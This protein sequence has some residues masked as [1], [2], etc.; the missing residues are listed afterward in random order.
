[1]AGPAA[2]QDS[3][4]CEALRAAQVVAGP[5]AQQVR[6]VEDR[7]FVLRDGIWTATRF[8]PHSMQPVLVGFGSLMNRRT[9]FTKWATGVPTSS[10]AVLEPVD[11]SEVIANLDSPAHPR[12]QFSMM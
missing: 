9:R 8:S 7:A 11:R 12:P 2:V 1:M 5:Q 4:T 10:P 3:V 6:H